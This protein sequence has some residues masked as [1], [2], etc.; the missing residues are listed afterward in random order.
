MRLPPSCLA[1][2]LSLA[3]P[4]FAQGQPPEQ[5]DKQRADDDAERRQELRRRVQALRMARLTQVLNLDEATAAKLFPLMNRHDTQSAALAEERA[6][7]LKKLDL[8]LRAEKEAELGPLLDRLA[9]VERELHASAETTHQKAREILT[10]AQMAQFVLF[11]ERFHEEVRD[12]MHDARK[13]ELRAD[14]HKIAARIH[15]LF[16]DLDLLAPKD[17]S[18][19][20][21][22]FAEIQKLMELFREHGGPPEALDEWKRHLHRWA[23][24]RGKLDPH[25]QLAEGERLLADLHGAILRGQLDAAEKLR[26]GLEEHVKRLQAM[27]ADQQKV[28]E[29]LLEK[30]KEIEADAKRRADKRE[31]ERKEGAR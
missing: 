9:Q 10:P 7:L 11:H 30:A 5:A 31:Q 27:G 21:P 3:S 20:A 6:Q 22:R 23:E 15:Q 29:A 25:L 12:V 8:A 2:A 28:A 17:P 16:E 19:V 4:L 1:L 14:H 18:A 24:L 13:D 26:R